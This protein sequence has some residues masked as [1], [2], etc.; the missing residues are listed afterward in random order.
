MISKAYPQSGF[1][2]VEL[3]VSVAIFAFMTA[4][5]VS[6]YGNFNENI[7]LT[8]VAYDVALA[9]RT[10]Q[11]YGLN[12]KSTPNSGTGERFSSQFNLAYGIHA[13]RGGTTFTFFADGNGDKKYTTS[14]SDVILLTNTLTNGIVVSDLEL[15]NGTTYTSNAVL[16]VTFKRPDP[17]AVISGDSGV[18]HS[19]AEILL[20][21]GT[22]SIK[23]VIIS[24][25]GQ[26]SVSD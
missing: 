14:S 25:T 5:L 7:L 19:Y 15:G 6:K 8:N 3:V 16:D 17:N 22:S 21:K 4:F 18:L 10:A 13:D 2:V 26:I 12:V 1:T 24:T 20:R 9:Y 23:K 11:T